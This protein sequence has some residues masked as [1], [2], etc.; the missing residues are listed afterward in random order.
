[1][2]RYCMTYDGHVAEQMARAWD[3]EDGR[4]MRQRING[5]PEAVRDHPDNYVNDPIKDRAE[6]NE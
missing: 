6:G 3:E 5:R 2:T 1:M 4:R